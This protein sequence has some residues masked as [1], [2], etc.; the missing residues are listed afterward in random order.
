MRNL[1]FNVGTIYLKVTPNACGSKLVFLFSIVTISL[2]SSCN[3]FNT[4]LPVPKAEKGKLDLRNWDFEKD[5][6]INLN[7][8]WEFYENKLL[9][10]ENFSSASPPSLPGWITV[11]SVWNNR[12]IQTD[13][14]HRLGY[15]TYRLVVLTDE[16]Q[17]KLAIKMLTASTAMEVYINGESVY[18]QGK[19][20]KS[21]ETMQP[22]YLPG[23]ATFNPQNK[24]IEIVIHVSN[25]YHRNGG[26]WERLKLGTEK[27]IY[28]AW[29]NTNGLHLFIV[30][31]IFIVCTYHL[32]S[33]RADRSSL[34]FSI[35]CFLI[36]I[37]I[38]STGECLLAHLSLLSWYWII[39]LD[40]LSFYLGA[41]AF[42]IFF[43]S[44]FPGLF[45]KKIAS[46]S[47]IPYGIA[48]TIVIFFPANV[49]THTT[50]PIQ[51]LTILMAAY[52]LYLLCVGY[53]RKMESI[54][55]FLLGFVAI[56]VSFINDV[57][58]AN[59]LIMTGYYSSVGIMFFI[60]TQKWQLSKQFSIAFINL[61]KMN[62]TLVEKNKQIEE[63]NETLQN[64]NKELDLF[65]HRTSH[66]LRA[67]IASVLGLIDLSRN[68]KD[69]SQIKNYLNLK[70]KALKKL[71]SFIG[72]M[73][74]YSRNSRTSLELN[75]IDFD[76]M[77][78]ETLNMYTHYNNFDRIKK[79]ID[80]SQQDVFVSD[81]KR[82]SVIFNN[83]ISN[84]I[85]YSNPYIES[86]FLRIKII[87]DTKMVKI[88]IKDNG[89][90][91]E[92]K[93]VDKIFDIFFR[94]NQHSSG[95]GLG[96]FLVKETVGKL[97]GSISVSSKVN[98]GSCF[99]VTLPNMKKLQP[100]ESSVY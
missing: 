34:Y 88:E 25:F 55:S 73:L 71:D 79:H 80:I 61:E 65:A 50:I 8:E 16:H 33:F 21:W 57:L 76:K 43:R 67:P 7:G 78:H 84:A 99:C 14:T 2:F 52:L 35:F 54:L 83:L 92:Q 85:R 44:V 95:S 86:P 3:Y 81:E 51:L 36:I 29:F 53:I 10:S 66:D 26:L 1:L 69:I 38:L 97:S 40:Y 32:L 18:K 72:D 17:N 22:Q 96:L 48:A 9:Y 11:P 63:Q 41:M 91:I 77:V 15:A 31:C 45:P 64:L 100:T 4:N 87:V 20:G 28:R 6:N 30:G 47:L 89:V 19:V 58:Y 68:E 39:K 49:F 23:V 56:Y 60:L 74:F 93:H 12:G 75:E 70:E 90:G 27:K 82:L 59:D 37:R 94:A 98:E 62:E 42:L 46:Y 5:G 13:K 24:M